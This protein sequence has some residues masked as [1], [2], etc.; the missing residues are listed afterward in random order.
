MMNTLAQ[1]FKCKTLRT[2]EVSLSVCRASKCRAEQVAHDP[3]LFTHEDPRTGDRSI[4]K[5]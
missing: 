1:R 3:V 4:K 5:L 2:T